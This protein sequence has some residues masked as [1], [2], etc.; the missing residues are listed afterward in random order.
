MC[1]R[2]EPPASAEKSEAAVVGGGFQ[3]VLGR[4]LIEQGFLDG[5]L[6][7][8]GKLLVFCRG[9][10]RIHGGKAELGCGKTTF[11]NLLAK[12]KADGLA[13]CGFGRYVAGSGAE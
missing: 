3:R 8:C 12:A 5:L 7:G 1:G 6:E 9:R 11:N 10:A 2:P 13:V 4:S